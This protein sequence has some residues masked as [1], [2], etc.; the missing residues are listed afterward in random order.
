MYLLTSKEIENSKRRDSSKGRVPSRGKKIMIRKPCLKSSL[1]L[2][3]Q[4]PQPLSSTKLQLEAG[5]EWIPP[6]QSRLII[7]MKLT[8]DNCWFPTSI[9]FPISKCY[10]AFFLSNLSLCISHIS[11]RLYYLISARFSDL[12][13][14]A[15]NFSYKHQCVQQWACDTI[16]I[17][18]MQREVW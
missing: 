18:D 6:F 8:C 1:M 10:P 3:L 5:A 2:I 9:H 16:W 12:S 17:N 14:V 4:S 11:V 15:I 13:Y 7:K